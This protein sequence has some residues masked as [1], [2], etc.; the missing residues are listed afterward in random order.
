ML[1][2]D[3]VNLLECQTPKF[4][5]I[6]SYDLYLLIVAKN[7]VCL[8]EMPINAHK[9][10]ITQSCLDTHFGIQFA[11]FHCYCKYCLDVLVTALRQ[12]RK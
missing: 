2:A 12:Q 10:C 7:G 1:Q 5:S 9:I 4:S 11:C 8:V 6:Q 3:I